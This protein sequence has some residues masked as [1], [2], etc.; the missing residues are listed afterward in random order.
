[1]SLRQRHGLDHPGVHGPRWLVGLGASGAA[2]GVFYARH[3]KFEDESVG[4]GAQS[5]RLG[6]AVSKQVGETSG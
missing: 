1:M 2:P 3:N 6:T 4:S 5:K